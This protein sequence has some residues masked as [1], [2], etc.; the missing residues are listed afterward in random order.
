M[1]FTNYGA[2]LAA[3][4]PTQEVE[5]ALGPNG[6]GTAWSCSHGVGRWYYDCGCQASGEQGW[7]QAWRTPLRRA[8]DLLRDWGSERFEEGTAD[9]LVD[10]WAAR[11]AYVELFAGPPLAP[12]KWLEPHAR[13]PL[14]D[15]EKRRTLTFLEMQKCLLLMYTSCGWFFADVSGIEPRQVMSYAGR[16]LDWMDE[17]ELDP[18]RARFLEILSEAK[19]NIP[20]RGSGADIFARV[21]ERLRV[22]ASRVASAQRVRQPASGALDDAKEF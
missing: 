11:N 19:S 14:D 12:D 9:L 21:V 16:A 2:F 8:F 4:P 20:E 7:N 6:Q 13:R 1:S 3:H 10:S 5:L 18:P 15:G 22:S 17:L